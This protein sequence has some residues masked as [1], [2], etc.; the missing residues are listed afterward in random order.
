METLVDL[1][2]GL[3]HEGTKTTKTHG[4]ARRERRVRQ[5]WATQI[6]AQAVAGE[7]DGWPAELPFVRLSVLRDFVL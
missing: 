4:G 6:E 7:I 3:K 5:R 2:S 1:P